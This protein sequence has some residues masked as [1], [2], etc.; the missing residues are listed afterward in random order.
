MTAGDAKQA[1][2]IADNCPAEL[3]NI[4]L[5][6]DEVLALLVRGNIVK[7]DVLITPLEVVDDALVRQLLLHDENVLEEVD[8]PLLDIKMIKLGN[9]RLLIFQIA[10]VLIDQRISLIDHVPDI[11]KN[12]RIGAHV[13]LGKL[14]RQ[15]LV[16]LLLLLQLVV[17]VLYLDVVALQFSDN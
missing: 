11:V 5:E 10:L 2:M 15:I 8:D 9:H 1:A 3:G 16:L 14:V 12:G 17:H 6:V 7:V 13:Q 4:V